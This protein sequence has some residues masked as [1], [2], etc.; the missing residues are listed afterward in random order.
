MESNYFSS[1]RKHPFKRREVAL[2]LLGTFAE[3][4]Q[5]FRVRNPEYN[6]KLVI[7]EALVEGPARMET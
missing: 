6:L 2:F 7:Q 1:H 4:I 5:M 3:D